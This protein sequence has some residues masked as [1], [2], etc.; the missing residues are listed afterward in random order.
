M[1]LAAIKAASCDELAEC[2]IAAARNA[3]LLLQDADLLAD[4]GRAARSCAL[5][6]L[7]IEETG[8][9]VELACLAIMPENLQARVPV[10][11]LLE[12]HG[13][14]VVGGM[15]LVV[16]PFGKIAATIAALPADQL[17]ERPR[18]LAPADETDRLKRRALYVDLDKRGISR[19]SDITFSQAAAQLCRARQSASSV[20]AL[21]GPEF[22][23]WLANPPADALALI[24]DLV[25][26]LTE[27]DG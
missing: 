27:A 25:T 16:L 15:L 11:H 8:K 12:W 18:I 2:A 13:L 20:S 14:K 10:R 26:A 7:C 6:A 17:A 4:A 19:P 22:S 5:A 23:A 9:A 21:L 3:Q 1:D 24:E